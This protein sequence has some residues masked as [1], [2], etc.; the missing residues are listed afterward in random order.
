M[1]LVASDKRQNETGK[2]YLPSLKYAKIVP[3]HN[4]TC[5]IRDSIRV[6]NGA[7]TNLTSY[8]NSCRLLISRVIFKVF[9]VPKTKI[10]K[11]LISWKILK[12][13]Y[14]E[15]VTTIWNNHP[16]F[17]RYQV[18]SKQGGRFFFKFCILLTISE[19]HELF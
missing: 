19:L 18:I 2:K 7:K 15:R 11:K 3:R 17:W 1:V 14:S 13:R 8:F 10:P 5:Q 16:L 9:I 4:I 6:H 12:F